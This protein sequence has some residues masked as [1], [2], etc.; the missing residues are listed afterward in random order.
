MKHLTSR[1]EFILV[2]KLSWGSKSAFNTLYREYSGILYSFALRYLKSDVEAGRFVHEVFAIIWETRE[3][4]KG[5][6]SLKSYLFTLSFD[7]IRR[8]FKIK[9]LNKE[10]HPQNINI[11]SKKP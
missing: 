2:R 8:N 6:T 3:E 11:D 4:L 7:I 9:T 10:I 5:E 1:K